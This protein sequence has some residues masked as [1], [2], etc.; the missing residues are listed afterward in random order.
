MMPP[1]G[2]LELEV[3]QVVWANSEPTAE[4]CDVVDPGKYALIADAKTSG[5]QRLDRIAHVAPQQSELEAA[6]SEYL[7]ALRHDPGSLTGPLS[8][9]IQAA[10]ALTRALDA[11]G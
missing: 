1:L 7:V 11:P 2:A 4:I 9:T 10:I 6:G 8:T 5:P 3:M